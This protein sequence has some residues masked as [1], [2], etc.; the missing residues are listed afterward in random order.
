MAM[1]AL[2]I[3]PLVRASE[4]TRVAIVVLEY[5]GVHRGRYSCQVEELCQRH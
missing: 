5:I 1:G 2:A 3:E 4:L